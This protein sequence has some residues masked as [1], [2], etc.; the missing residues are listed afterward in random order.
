MSKGLMENDPAREQTR[1]Q[2]VHRKDLLVEKPTDGGK[3]RAIVAE[4][5][6]AF[7]RTYFQTD[8][9]SDLEC[10]SDFEASFDYYK[11]LVTLDDVRRR[12][13]RWVK[14]NCDKVAKSFEDTG[15]LLP[16]WSDL[17]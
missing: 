14:W 3:A 9:L 15:V 1:R 10:N 4:D 17:P 8:K 2:A 11:P 5:I 13:N 16:N 12:I 7:I 6:V